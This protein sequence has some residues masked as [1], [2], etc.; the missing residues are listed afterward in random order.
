MRTFVQLICMLLAGLAACGGGGSTPP[1]PGSTAPFG[2]TQRVPITG[3]A[4]PDT[5]GSSSAEIVRAFDN[6][7]FSSPVQ[8][9]YAP[10]GTDRIF[11]VEV[12]GRIRVFPNS[13]SATSTTTFLDITGRVRSGGEEGLLG[14]AFDPDYATKLKAAHAVMVQAMKCKQ[15]I[16]PALAADLKAKILA[17]HKVYEIKD[18][19]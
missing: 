9:T 5:Q 11:V 8:L 15:A 12:A 7:V 19:S 3:L 4:F 6:L 16:D 14:L 2:L 1:P 18:A 13:D 17:F 10:D